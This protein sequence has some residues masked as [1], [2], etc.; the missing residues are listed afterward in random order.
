MDLLVHGISGTSVQ[1]RLNSGLISGAEMDVSPWP[2]AQLS[3]TLV[4]VPRCLQLTA[5]LRKQVLN[6]KVPLLDY[7][8][9][10]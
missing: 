7:S 5:D 2:A 4:T 9:I 3:P 8:L 1:V 10:S 6:M